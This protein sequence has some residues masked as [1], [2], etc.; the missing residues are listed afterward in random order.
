MSTWTDG[1]VNYIFVVKGQVH[2]NLTSIPFLWI[3]YHKKALRELF[4]PNLQQ[5]STW[6]QRQTDFI[7]TSKVKVNITSAPFLSMLHLKGISLHAA[8]TSWTNIHVNCKLKGYKCNAVILV[9][10][11]FWNRYFY[12]YFI[13]FSVCFW[14][15]EKEAKVILRYL[16][17]FTML[18]IAVAAYINWLICK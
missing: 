4:F 11:T 17:L 5:I 16:Y 1:W 13:F 14:I 12:Y 15:L 8:Q 3:C 9:L 6:M 18:S 10:L 7:Q 2:C